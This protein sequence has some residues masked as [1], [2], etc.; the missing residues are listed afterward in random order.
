[1]RSWAGSQCPPRVL[2]RTAQLE[3]E[4][5]RQVSEELKTARPVRKEGIDRLDA[6]IAALS[7]RADTNAQHVRDETFSLKHFI[8]VPQSENERETDERTA[9]CLAAGG[10]P[11]ACAAAQAAL[12]ACIAAGSSSEN[13]PMPQPG[14]TCRWFRGRCW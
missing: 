13:A 11:E 4:A 6:L 14:C 9:S 8:Q 2:R 10:C 3:R 5:L 7:G 1:M 12:K